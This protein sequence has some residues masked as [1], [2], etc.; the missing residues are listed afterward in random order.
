MPTQ[1]SSIR[2]VGTAPDGTGTL[3]DDVVIAPPKPM[4]INHVKLVQQVSPAF[5]GKKNNP[6]IAL[7]VHTSGNLAPKSVQQIFLN[8]TNTTDLGDVA[9]IRILQGERQ[10][11][12]DQ[13]ASGKLTFTGSQALTEGE[14]VFHVSFELQPGAKLNNRVDA[15]ITQIKIDGAFF[16]PEPVQLTGPQRIG[17]AVRIGGQDNCHTYR[18][19]G[20]ATT[21]KG[22]VI[23][24]YDNR[25]QSSG[26][27][28]GDIDVGMSRSTDGGQSWQAMKV[29]M[30]MGSDPKWRFDGIGDPSI[31]VDR[32]TGRIWVS[33]TW[34]HGNR[35]W[36]GS[37]PGM[38]PEETG[39]WMMV[40]SD[41]DGINW[42]QPI[43]I[44]GQIKNP[45]WRYI[46]QGPGNGITMS[47]GT[48]VF[49]AQ[50]RG[51]NAAPVNGKPFSTLIYSKDRG[52]TWNV[53]TGVKID[54]TEAQLVELSDGSIMINCRD[55]RN[56][57][58]PDGKN[59]RTV[60]V[61]HD[62]GATWKLHP[63]D[64]TVLPEPTCMASLIK[65]ESGPHKNLLV[66][67]NPATGQ[68]RFNMTLKAS[69]DQG[70]TWPD[71]FHLLYDSRRG[72]GYS[73]L[74]QIDDD[75][76]GVLYEGVRNLYFLRFSLNEM[77]NSSQ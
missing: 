10:F 12:G 76:V 60:A 45:K 48:L 25:Y 37:G 24:V 5:S 39:Q 34:S 73:C 55:N 64:R 58:L 1:T 68:G 43:N 47:D 44:T 65:L 61:T 52:T 35:A 70:M 74:T 29:I 63:T 66:F 57:G 36:F 23:A 33:A 4:T 51:E 42:S 27:L 20:L 30:D 8:T 9:A 18:I 50:F 22:T 21:N 77:L 2:F 17:S 40:F 15:R 46:L 31:L 69:K 32:Q 71:D 6:V 16:D 7:H 38:K 28:P 49:P 11:G 53:G 26:D 62:L 54:T 59:G 14:N 41:D 75:H 67:S 19:P 13:R 72:A 3:I 56:R